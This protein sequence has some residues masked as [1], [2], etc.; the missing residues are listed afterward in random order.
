[1]L[2]LP[3]NIYEKRYQT[4]PCLVMYQV[5]NG[6]LHPVVPAMLLWDFSL[7]FSFYSCEFNSFLFAIVT[8][9]GSRRRKFAVNDFF[10]RFLGYSPVKE[11]LKGRLA[12][13]RGV[14]GVYDFY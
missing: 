5:Y 8:N 10:D 1:M 2:I 3:S 12:F 9:H 7:Q 13:N 11:F 4:H 14:C 6:R